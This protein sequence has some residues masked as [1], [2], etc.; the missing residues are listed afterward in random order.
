MTVTVIVTVTVTVIVIVIVTVTV[1]VIVTRRRPFASRPPWP[2]NVQ[3]LQLKIALTTK[4]ARNTTTIE[5]FT[6]GGTH[7]GVPF[8]SRAP[9][10]RN[11]LEVRH[12]CLTGMLE[13]CLTGMFDRKVHDSC[14]C[15]ISIKVG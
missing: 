11:A 9:F 2:R 1:T 7:G 10:P 6:L 14:T 8:A 4:G 15:R 3:T 12:E 5:K 13:E